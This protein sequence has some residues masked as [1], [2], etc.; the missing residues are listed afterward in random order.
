[1]TQHTEEEGIYQGHKAILSHVRVRKVHT[2]NLSSHFLTAMKK[3]V[4]KQ[5]PLC[6]Y[7]TLSTSQAI[8]AT[9]SHPIILAAGT[10]SRA[11][12]D[13]SHSEASQGKWSDVQIQPLENSP[14]HFRKSNLPIYSM[15]L[16][17]NG[18]SLTDSAGTCNCIVCGAPG[19]IPQL[20]CLQ[21]QYPVCAW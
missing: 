13:P 21:Q 12:E 3:K 18:C 2:S 11:G 17:T 20:Q 7:S 9:Q 15:H 10:A 16:Q 19:E 1:M 6:K 14:L 8:S 4:A 5:L